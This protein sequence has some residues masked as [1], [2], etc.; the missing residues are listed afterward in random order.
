MKNLLA[1]AGSPRRGGNSELLLDE[2]IKAANDAGLKTNKLVVSELGISPCTSCGNCWETGECVIEDKMQEVYKKLLDADYVVVASPLY[3]LG[4]SAQLKALIDRCQALW[5]R[6]FVLK[7]PLR[8]GGK[9]PRGLFISTA[10]I[11]KAEDT[12]FSGSRQTM[13][14]IFN[15]L[16]IEYAGELFFKGLDKR[17]AITAHPEFLEQAYKTARELIEG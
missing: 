17:D 3:F 8:N 13:R 4:I 10:A 6:R 11:S 9:Q 1:I 2:V 16:E 12:I 7:R 5:S 15:A 14:A